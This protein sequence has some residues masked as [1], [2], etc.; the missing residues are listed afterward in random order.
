MFGK[1]DYMNDVYFVRRAL[2]L[3]AVLVELRAAAVKR[4]L[5]LR[6]HFTTLDGDARRPALIVADGGMQFD[7]QCLINL[8]RCA[9]PR[10]TS[11][12]AGGVRQT[13]A[14]SSEC[15]QCALGARRWRV[16]QM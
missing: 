12:V 6:F 3:C 11:L 16:G 15:R 9:M 1:R 2:Y 10:R 4:S 5:P 8:C 7:R 13:V 14:I